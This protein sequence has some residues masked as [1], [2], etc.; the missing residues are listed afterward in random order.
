MLPLFGCYIPGVFLMRCGCC[1]YANKAVST[2]VFVHVWFTN[3]YMRMLCMLSHVTYDHA[4]LIDT[5]GVI[6]TP[7]VALE[8][9]RHQCFP[10]CRIRILEL[11]NIPMTSKVPSEEVVSTRDQ[12]LCLNFLGHTSREISYH[13]CVCSAE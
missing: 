12:G 2:L 3:K 9:T 6:P 4:R 11:G 5:G 1:K 8:E 10:V 13:A 7:S